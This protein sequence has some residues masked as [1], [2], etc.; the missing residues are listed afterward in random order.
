MML[1]IQ[2]TSRIVDT[3]LSFGDDDL[4]LSAF[5]KYMRVI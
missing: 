2:V 3:E 1:T 5:C 4:L